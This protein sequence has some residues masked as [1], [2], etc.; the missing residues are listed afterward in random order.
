MNFGEDIMIRLYISIKKKSELNLNVNDFY[1]N[2]NITCKN[3][4][5]IGLR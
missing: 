3:V 4:A 2:C 5:V 1:I